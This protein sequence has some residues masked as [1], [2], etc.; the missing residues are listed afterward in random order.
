MSKIESV[1]DTLLSEGNVAY[2]GT[3]IIVDITHAISK[4][5]LGIDQF[6]SQTYD[7]SVKSEIHRR[8]I[9]SYG[10]LRGKDFVQKCNT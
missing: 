2:Y 3:D 8:I 1:F 5:E 7:D 9:W 10:R 6:F 4:E